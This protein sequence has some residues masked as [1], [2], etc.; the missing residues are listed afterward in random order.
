[1]SSQ[2]FA[3]KYAT[4]FATVTASYGY[5]E[6][7]LFR[8]MQKYLLS[9]SSAIQAEEYH[10]AGHQVTFNGN[11]IHSRLSAR[12]EL[13]DLLIIVY[14]P[15]HGTARYTYLQAKSE[16]GTPAAP[17]SHYYSGN[18]EQ[19]DLL[20]RRP[21]IH[22]VGKF[23]PHPTLLSSALLPSIGSF[24]LFYKSAQAGFQMLY[25]AADCLE[26][27]QPHS[28]RYG[29]MNL[30]ASLSS[31]RSIYGHVE[32][33]YTLDNY[34]FAYYLHNL[35]IGE[36][37]ITNGNVS[38]QPSAVWI[39]GVINA[40]A[41]RP[42][43]PDRPNPLIRQLSAALNRPSVI[44]DSV[45]FGAKTMIVVGSD[46]NP[47]QQSKESPVPSGLDQTTSNAILQPETRPDP[48]LLFD[49]SPD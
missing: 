36:P 25:A 9:T 45:R 32:Q 28:V 29:K 5:D 35:M 17:Q 42:S 12:C 44:G 20:S 22:G 46:A 41:A 31:G 8:A 40:L 48:G 10:G 43:D 26:P 16:R 14:S 18:L 30:K 27:K 13:S 23:H 47:E 34:D 3:K 37:L 1:M 33:T 6:V 24:G 2:T 49:L 7:R 4:D 38:D 19:W 39:T 21:I 11:N 15:E